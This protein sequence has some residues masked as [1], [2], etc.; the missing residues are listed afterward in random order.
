M[1]VVMLI[2]HEIIVVTLC[3]SVVVVIN[4]WCD[5]ACDGDDKISM[6]MK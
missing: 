3:A 5:G 1:I 2:T 6:V 4:G